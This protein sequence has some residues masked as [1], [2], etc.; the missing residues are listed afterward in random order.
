M[1]TY[2]IIFGV[3]LIVPIW[4]AP[5]DEDQSLIISTTASS[6]GKEFGK[7]GPSG[8]ASS[9]PQIY[10][11]NIKSTIKNRF[12][13]TTVTSKVRNYANKA[14]EAV[15]SIILPESAYISGFVMEIDEKNYTA[16][17]KEKEEAQKTYDEAISSG[18]SAAH[19]SV[20][21]R[22]SNRF[23]VNVNVEPQKKAAFYLSYEQLLNRQ[24]G[25]YEQVINIHPGQYIEDLSAEVLISETRKIIDLK[26]PPL[27]SGNEVSDEVK[28]LD[29][30]VYIEVV[31][32]KTATVK[33]SPNVERQKQ[34]AHI[35]G[36]K[37]E[38]GFAGQFVLQYDV[39]RDPHGG[40]VL[41]QDG[42]FVHFFAPS[43]I[44][45]LAKQVVFILDTSGSMWGDK[46]RQL[47]EAMNK[48]LEQLN[49]QDSFNLVEFNSNARVWDLN[50]NSASVWYPHPTN[51][52]SYSVEDSN[53]I[54]LENGSFPR[55]YS[56]NADNI[57][58]AKNAVEKLQ[59]DGSTGMYSALELGLHLV[60][61]ERLDKNNNIKR[62]PM[63]VFLTD[64]DPTDYS[65][66]EIA[67]KITE[68][69]V[70]PRK[71]PIFALSFGEGA[72]K[73]F[74]QTLSL[75]NSGFSRHIYEAAD[76][77][78]QLQDFYKQISSPLLS[79][80]HFKYEPT[81]TSLTNTEFPIHFG[82]SELVVAGFCGART[83]TPII[84]G[85]GKDGEVIFKP[86]VIRS[87]SNIERLW[88]YLTISQLLEKK[89]SSKNDDAELKKKALDLALKYSFVTSVTSLVVVKP[90]ETKPVDTVEA[91]D[92]NLDTFDRISSKI[93]SPLFGSPH[94]LNTV[95]QS[96]D[97]IGKS[98]SLLIL[99]YTYIGISDIRTSGFHYDSIIN[100]SFEEELSSPLD[101]LLNAL[102]WLSGI[103]IDGFVNTPNGK[104]KL[105][106]NET[107]NDNAS[108][109]KT[110]LNLEGHCAL[111]HQCP[112]IHNKLIT[113][114][115][116]FN[117]LCVLQNEFA[118]VC[119]PNDP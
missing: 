58:K 56:A 27:R 111:L 61:V 70:G 118:G 47:K 34:L 82:G 44:K 18:L 86:V 80:V 51:Q 105:G 92:D 66:I 106:A 59:S 100:F 46:I 4:T 23:T 98:I 54:T 79:D 39:E 40:E 3:I 55:A 52:W 19:V 17:V 6:N 20:S 29:P 31:D 11:M 62:Q 90:N 88:A 95:F 104:Y 21:A 42:Y 35:I 7:Q 30:R 73:I 48:I 85:F 22:D 37:E 115:D 77:S 32:E 108:C 91:I 8:L 75:R 110:P 36:T 26:A 72:D 64:G 28:D 68:F 112:S 87:V 97:A 78:L 33:F 83:P 65:T 102:S 69:N 60:Q 15:F 81:V 12:A 5:I 96:S 94:A 2:S 71:A 113:S 84:D 1:Q 63:I 99:N 116:F 76:A 41:V 25:R 67:N 117:H 101:V 13:H 45:P 57:K 10:Q 119:C 49:E 16:Y 103:L 53:R 107:I 93:S 24:E 43:D 14:Q 38:N 9:P 109:P 74:L 114:Q 50:D 89:E